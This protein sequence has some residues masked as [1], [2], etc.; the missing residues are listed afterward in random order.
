MSDDRTEA[1]KYYEVGLSDEEAE[2][3]SIGVREGARVFAGQQEQLREALV[4][5]RNELHRALLERGSTVGYRGAFDRINAALAA[6]PEP[7]GE[8][9]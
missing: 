8:D 9:Q 4:F 5:A 6:S 7:E 1:P 2:A 3:Y